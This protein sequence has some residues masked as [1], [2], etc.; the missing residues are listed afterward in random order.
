MLHSTAALLTIGA[1][2]SVGIADITRYTNPVIRQW[3]PGGLL[4]V[5]PVGFAWQVGREACS[6]G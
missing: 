6:T 2:L 4:V 1:D 5:D 3:S